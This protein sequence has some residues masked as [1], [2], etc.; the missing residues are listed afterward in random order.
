MDGKVDFDVRRPKVVAIV[1]LI[2][3]FATV[4]VPGSVGSWV[5]SPNETPSAEDFAMVRVDLPVRGPEM[6]IKPL[7]PGARSDGNLDHG[8]TMLEPDLRE[9]PPQARPSA[10]L[11]DATAGS[12]KKNLWRLDTNLSWYGPGFYGKRTACGLAM[13]ESLVGVAHR[14]LPCGT[15][16]TFKNPANGRIVTAPVVDRGPYVAGR[17]WDLTGGLCKKLGHCYTGSMYWKYAAAG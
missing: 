15:M 2:A 1:A 14:T 13:T 3:T 8:S 6:T 11:P 16:I 4:A 5:P 10:A 7:D 12:I 9:E 17:R